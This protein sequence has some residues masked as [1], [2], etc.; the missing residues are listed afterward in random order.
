MLSLTIKSIRANKARFFLTGVAVLLGVA[1]MAGTFVLTDT[2]KKSYDD[3]SANVYRSTDAVVR[4]AR[5]TESSNDGAA[6]RGTIAASTLATVRSTPGVEA[7]E[8][9]QLGIA[10]VVARNG[11]LLDARPDRAVPVALGWQETAKL[12]PL[13]LV[14]GHGPQAPD[15]IVIDKASAEKGQFQLGETVHVVSPAGSQAYRIAG[16]ATYGGAADAAGAQVVAFTPDT[17]SMVFGTPGRYSAIQVIAAPGVSQAQLTTNLRNALHDPTIEVITGADA[18][19][20]ASD[21]TAAPLKFVNIALMTFAIVALVVGSFVIYN[22]FSITVAQR[23]KE[24]AML[25]AIGAKRRQVMRSIRLEAFFTGLFASTAGVAVGIALA[26]GLRSV[27]S[28]FGLDLPAG[29][30]VVE[31][32]TIA[33][34]MLTGIVV[35]VIAAWLPARRAAK[36]APIEAL[37]DTAAEATAHSK[38]RIVLGTVVT[39][40]GVLFI[41]QGLSGAGAGAV[42]FGALGV[43]FGVAMLGPVISRRFARV[44]GWPLPRARG[45]AG[46]L[47]RE[48]A[49]RNP[50]RTAATSSALMIGVALVAFITVFAASA[51]ASISTSVDR[52]MR[53]D[54]IITTQFGMGGLSPDVAQRI[55]AL[56]ET[57][58]V[59]A[60]RYFD[61]QVGGSSTQASAVD[62]AK[63]EGS[64]ELELRQ[65]HITDLGTNGVAVQEDVAKSKNL[66]VGDP[67]TMFFPETGDQQ[68][69]VVAIY[70]VKEPMGDYAISTQT[71]DANTATHVDNDIVVSAAPGVAKTDARAAI[72]DV[73]EDFPTAKLMTKS[74]FKGSMANRIDQIL[75]LVYVL[76]AMALVIALFGIANTLALSVFERTREFGLLRA[77]GMSRAQ[78][79]STVR[80]E[81]VLIA[82]LGTSLGT[83]IGLGFASSLVQALE[84]Q[85]FNTFTV[86]VVQLTVIV[87][88]SAIAAVGAAALPARR[89]A[90]LDVL[91]AIVTE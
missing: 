48:N 58:A 19:T 83:V 80:W 62:P 16:V 81:S 56:P 28:A 86:P 82:L 66:H 30:A 51:K 69:T 50:R 74:E 27:L 12:N 90:R 59:T 36:V 54:W 73:L 68:L 11:T 15:E 53:T 3:I 38:R 32:R 41:A 35:T 14:S 43:F 13:E 31:T 5:E 77:V 33:V 78:V 49:M 8:P 60:L 75:N 63:V 17:A 85:G 72:Q 24:T 89:A 88:L 29:G 79:R 84:K 20:E 67:L 44:V 39:A 23:T 91:A 6:T 61:A 26:Q 65:G 7:A 64:V 21:A 57:G 70:G 9:Q 34:S 4:S 52:A 45:M 55:D 46:T 71:F 10:V 22:T 2:I 1:F 76:L 40:A 47:A 37:R 25:R 87:V 42:G 18:S